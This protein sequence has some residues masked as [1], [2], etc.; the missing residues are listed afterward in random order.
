M[1]IG[2]VY[3]ICL[4]AVVALLLVA[5]ES[6]RD[7]STNQILL[8][9]VM[10]IGNG[11]YCALASSRNEDE[12]ILASK[13]TYLIGVFVPLLLL[14]VVCEICNI[15]VN[16][17][18]KMILMTVQVLIYGS[19]C[20]IGNLPIY[21][22][23]VE[24]HRENGFAYIT[25]TYG[26]MHSFYIISLI[27]YMIAVVVIAVRAT[28]QK[29]KVSSRNLTIII[30]LEFITI[31]TY[32]VERI[33]KTN[34]EMMPVANTITLFFLFKAVTRIRMYSIPG[35]S[36]L[37][38]KMIS[39]LGFIVLDTKLRY[40]G[41]NEMASRIFPELMEWELDKKIPGSGG[42]FNTFLRQP[43][44]AYI[45]SN[46]I[47]ECQGTSFVIKENKY[48]YSFDTLRNKSGNVKGYIIEIKDVT[49]ILENK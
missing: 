5:I 42:R 38:D 17:W 33:T 23:S 21:Y 26:F 41:C 20:T 49:T 9:M 2:I 37:V 6:G 19:V 12:A 35:N 29:S 11:G 15:A 10:T 16:R 13:L 45:E 7:Y 43:M 40:M 18:L 44:M 31:A 24:Y 46:S 8:I 32:F 25:K 36:A 27:V 39:S 1:N 30:A 47:E 28:Q 3:F 14:L 22:K 34:V 48:M 4:I